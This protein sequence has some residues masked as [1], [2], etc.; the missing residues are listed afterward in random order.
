[1]N[2]DKQEGPDI[3]A[4]LLACCTFA[5]AS[6]CR[7]PPALTILEASRHSDPE[8]SKPTVLNEPAGSL[9]WTFLD[10][11]ADEEPATDRGLRPEYVSRLI[12]AASARGPGLLARVL[13]MRSL[14]YIESIDHQWAVTYL[15]PDL[16]SNRP[17][18][19][20]MWRSFAGGPIGTARFFNAVKTPMLEAF[21]QPTMRAALADLLPASA[22][23][24]VPDLSSS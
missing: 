8:H 21:E 20:A 13:R 15:I 3:G 12:L 9:A 19:A 7:I 18:A 11:V 24:P 14:S 6:R 2:C 5:P 16:V 22:A 1:V 17:H 4:F 10:Q 23:L